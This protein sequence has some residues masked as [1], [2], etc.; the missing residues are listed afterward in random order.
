MFKTPPFINE[1]VITITNFIGVEPSRIV[2]SIIISILIVATI[3]AVVV[4]FSW[5]RSLFRRNEQSDNTNKTEAQTKARG[6]N[7]AVATSGAEYERMIHD[8]IEA[9]LL[10]I[11]RRIKRLEDRASSSAAADDDT[12]P[13]ATAELYNEVQDVVLPQ[14]EDVPKETEAPDTGQHPVIADE[15]VEHTTVAPMQDTGLQ[16][17]PEEEVEH[18]TVAQIQ[19][20]QQQ[21]ASPSSEDTGLQAVPPSAEE[22]KAVEQDSNPEQKAS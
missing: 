12:Q 21:E 10:P 20:S 16:A 14:A 4:V 22:D 9:A 6:T 8:A 5:L 11:D 19:D 17:V 2:R 13:I 18:T 1:I 7:A 3:V 15:E